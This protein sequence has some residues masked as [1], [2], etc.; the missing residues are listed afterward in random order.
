MATPEN[1][2][3]LERITIVN[4]E[5]LDS[6]SIGMVDLVYDLTESMF[7]KVPEG[8]ERK[9]FE[10]AIEILSA[11]VGCNFASILAR[12]RQERAEDRI[13]F[14]P[15][16][17]KGIFISY[18]TDSHDFGNFNIYGGLRDVHSPFE[19]KDTDSA[20]RRHHTKRTDSVL[21]QTIHFN[22]HVKNPEGTSISDIWYTYTLNKGFRMDKLILE[23]Q[24][25]D[26][27]VVIEEKDSCFRELKDRFNAHARTLAS[28]IPSV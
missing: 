9:G 26:I 5:L 3:S 24:K 11:F 27:S 19:L 2:D 23:G 20:M 21:S 14:L 12:P 4:K 22:F 15:G 16:Q 28:L 18:V 13:H 25:I 6:A 17:H 8:E 10:E 1:Q 7:L